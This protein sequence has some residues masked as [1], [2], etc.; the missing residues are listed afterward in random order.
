VEAQVVASNDEKT[1]YVPTLGGTLAA[2]DRDGSLGLRVA[3]GARAYAT[4]LV[5]RDGTLFVGCDGGALLAVR[6]SGAIQWRLETDGDA[7]T[8]PVVAPDGTLVFAAGSRV[9]GVRAGRVVFRFQAHAKVFTSPAM[10]GDDGSSLF[11]IGSQDH[12]VYALTHAGE[13]AWTVDL[14]H[15]VD[16]SPAID[17]HG[18]IF[19]GTDGDEVV[20]L[21]A[22][23]GVS[24]RTPLGGAV[25]GPLSIARNGDVLAGV[26]GPSARL[27]RLSPDGVV[28]ASFDVRGNGSRE[29][30]VYGGALE[31]DNGA[32][33]FGA[34]DGFVRVYERDGSLR[35]EMDAGADVDAPLTLLR[36]GS[37]IVA[38]Y[39][40]DV[41]MLRDAP[42]SG[43][44]E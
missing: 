31:D 27:V 19:V 5:D 20:R 41:T 25:R 15:D 3:L 30:G 42:A 24:W 28:T 6:P 26:Y 12:H 22:Q 35:W 1:L 33:A 14:A 2:L 39:A 18:G 17:D 16:G 10:T 36:D 34:Q 8:S 37:L 23:G 9:Y 29:T 38:S 11:V 43:P 13:L 4:P 32:L 7:D 44:A 21:D 40:G